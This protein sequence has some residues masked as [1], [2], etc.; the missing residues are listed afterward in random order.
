ML[1]SE[2]KSKVELHHCLANF[3]LSAQRTIILTGA[4]I[5]TEAGIPDFRSPGTGLWEK[6]DSQKVFSAE[7][8]TRHPE[9]FYQQGLKLL[10]TWQNA[11]PTKAHF[12]LARME[13]KKIIRAIITQNIDG[14]HQKAGSR[15]VYE[16]HGNLREGTCQ[17]CYRKYPLKEILKK[18]PQQMPPRC[19]S[20]GEILKPDVVFF[21]DPLPEDFHR[22][23]EE[24]IQ[25]DFLWVIGSSLVV[26]PAASLPA[27][28]LERGAKLA[29]VNLQ[30]TPYEQQANLVIHS[31]I[32]ETIDFLESYI[33]LKTS[34]NEKEVRMSDYND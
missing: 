32:G 10:L 33:R 5:S 12:F 21:G 9:I 28:A 24:V 8:F 23:E 4:G 16:I 2:N 6:L 3:L 34:Y 17:N 20:C 22:A 7:A 29:I 14:L 1:K 30:P 15:K 19:D 27:L 31:R 26:E 18:L 25:S 13:K 11:Q